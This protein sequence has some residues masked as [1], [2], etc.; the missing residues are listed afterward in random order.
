M[1]QITDT[2]DLQAV[3]VAEDQ[4]PRRNALMHAFSSAEQV[5]S[6]LRTI[7]TDVDVRGAERGVYGIHLFFSRNHL[8]VME[9]ARTFDAEVSSSPSTHMAGVFLEARARFQGVEL[10]AWTIVDEAPDPDDHPASRPAE[11][12]D[13]EPSARSVDEDP[14]AYSL[15]EAA[16][17]QLGAE[18]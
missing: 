1:Q 7:P 15:T 2:V 14:I 3:V 4:T 11:E 6:Q 10:H 5:V 12:P 8:G 16:E 13:E 17:T 18:A 9:V